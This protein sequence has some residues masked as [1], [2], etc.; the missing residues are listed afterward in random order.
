[1]AADDE[2]GSGSPL[3]EFVT[4]ATA[5]PRCGS[6]RIIA[7]ESGARGGAGPPTDGPRNAPASR[8]PTAVASD[9]GE[10]KIGCRTLNPGMGSA[11]G[12]APPWWHCRAAPA[13]EGCSATPKA[14]ARTATVPNS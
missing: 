3:A 2:S 6:S 1:M 14:A 8:R 10:P 5:Q 13:P 7:L 12:T 4:A 9:P 11:G